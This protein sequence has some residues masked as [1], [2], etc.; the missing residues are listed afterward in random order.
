MAHRLPSLPGETPRHGGA[1]IAASRAYGIAAADW[2]DLSTGINP[3]AYPLKPFDRDDVARL[4]DPERLA[5]LIDAARQAYGARPDTEILPVGGTDLAIRLLPMLVPPSAVAILSPT[6]SGHGEAWRDAGHRVLAVRDLRSALAAAPIVVLANP[7][8]PDGRTHEAAELVAAATDGAVGRLLIVDEAFC[9]LTPEI[10]LI[11]QLPNGTLVLRSFGKFYGLAGLRLGFVVGSGA[12]V[13]RLRRVL[14]DW[15]VSGPAI[16]AGTAALADEPWQAA[17]RERLA[18]DRLRLDAALFAHDLDRIEGTDLF[19]T[20][21]TP[22]AADLHVEL[23]RRGVWTRIFDAE[24][25]RIRIGLP[26]RDAFGRWESALA[27]A[28]ARI[29]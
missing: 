5:S 29:S 8:N 17:T 23:A 21:H 15:P 10:S 13:E 3:L 28:V 24:T 2:L 7:N 4:P 26:A 19:R 14:G 11:P 6:Y 27:E 25:D 20:V 22:L 1:L 16:A 9:D 12:T 18:L